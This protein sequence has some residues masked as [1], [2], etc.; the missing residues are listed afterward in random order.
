[1]PKL[2]LKNIEGF[3]GLDYVVVQGVPVR[4]SK[5]GEVIQISLD[6]IERK[7]AKKI[8]E[9]GVPVRGA[10]VRFLRKALGLSLGRLGAA[11]GL[12][13]TAILKW[14]KEPKK[15]LSQI[16]EAVVRS[17]FAETLKLKINGWFSKLVSHSET[18]EIMYL[19][20][21]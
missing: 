3:G 10:E 1:M 8:I 14:E 21:G 5:L 19:K 20:A 7:V 12:S 16:N 13:G 6:D 2:K 9:I 11:L 18:P 17:F 4:S 15:R